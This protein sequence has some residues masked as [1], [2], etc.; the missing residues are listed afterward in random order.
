[1]SRESEFQDLFSK[2]HAAGMAALLTTVPATM[3]LV[4]TDSDG[5]MKVIVVPDG[6][7]GFAWVSIKPATAPFAKWLKATGKARGGNCSGGS[8]LSYWVSE[9]SQSYEK[10][11]RYARAFADV[12]KAANLA[13]VKSIY[14]DGRLD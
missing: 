6:P 5:V 4:G 11:R 12:L 14:A 13:G 1:M 3:R 10:K 2:A 8:G 9:G 7:C